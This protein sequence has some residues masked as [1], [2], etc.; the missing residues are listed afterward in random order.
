[1]AY[2]ERSS[3]S[4]ARDSVRRRLVRP[5]MKKARTTK[6]LAR[7]LVVLSFGGTLCSRTERA[8]AAPPAPADADTD[9]PRGF[10]L[11][12]E[13]PA[14]CPSR[15][16][17]LAAVEARRPPRA[18]RAADTRTF[19]VRLRPSPR[20]GFDARLDVARDGE[21]PTTRE[22]HAA[23][24]SAAMTSM[25][26][27]I[28][29]ALAPTDELTGAERRMEPSDGGTTKTPDEPPESTGPASN[30]RGGGLAGS[31]SSGARARP[32]DQAPS[33]PS[34]S[35]PR[36]AS[37]AAPAS[38]VWTGG[39][40][41]VTAGLGA[42]ATGARGS[43]ELARVPASTRLGIAL[44]LSW[45]WADFSL[46]PPRAGEARFRLNSTR[47]E[48][49]LVM[50]WDRLSI[51]ACGAAELGALSAT[52]VGLPVSGRATMAWIAAGASARIR[53]HIVHGLSLEAGMAGLVPFARR[54]FALTEPVRGIFRPTPVLLEGSLG[55]QM[56]ATF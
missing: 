34:A 26:V 3:L 12:Y 50:P 54:T 20:G 41:L 14:S 33:L 40:S 24:C 1:M 4:H 5:G 18:S 49:C 55:V 6:A 28:T 30:A 31:A 56:S 7:L 48:P 19:V 29:L 32:S 45:G 15:E 42:R 53:V 17:L 25:A 37:P 52:A 27:F 43:G 35:A 46:F 39:A 23:S 9:R 47:A 10:S 16:A 36:L 51:S 44:R 13:A 21:A 8:G 11:V 22:V 38:L 2:G